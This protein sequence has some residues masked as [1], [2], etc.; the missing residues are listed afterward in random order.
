MSGKRRCKILW[1]CRTS[2]AENLS[3]KYD[4]KARMH[5]LHCIRAWAA[6][7]YQPVYLSGRQVCGVMDLQRWQKAVLLIL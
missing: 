5:A 7:G 3:H 6:Q 4:V 1:P 2:A